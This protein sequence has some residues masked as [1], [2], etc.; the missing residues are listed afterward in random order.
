MH[1]TE[2]LDDADLADDFCRSAMETAKAKAK[3]LP[4]ML[5]KLNY[6]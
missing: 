2:T 6:I 1:I 4:E 5:E 3:T